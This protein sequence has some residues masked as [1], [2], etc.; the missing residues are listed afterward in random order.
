MHFDALTLA[1][2]ADE[3]RR[4]LNDGRVQQVL[5]PNALSVGLEI[6]AHHQRHYLML[7]TG[8]PTGRVFLASDKLRRGVEQPSP[9][10]LLLRK[11]LR[12]SSVVAIQQPSPTERVLFLQFEHAEHGVAT[13]I[14]EILGQRSNLILRNQA[15][16]ILECLHRVWPGERVVRPLAPGQ[17]YAL[18]PPQNKL[19]PFDDGA[20]EYYTQLERLIQ[21]E[22]K[23]WKV[24]STGVAGV[25]PTLGR[26]IA[27]RT[28]GDSEAS[29]QETPLLGLIQALQGLWA[30]VQTGE[31]Q[32]GV[33]L[34][35]DHPVGYSAYV[36]HLDGQFTPTPSMSQ[37]L[38]AYYGRQQAGTVAPAQDPYAGLRKT[39][40]ASLRRAQQRIQRQLDALAGDE[41]PPGAAEELRTEAEWLLALHTQIQPG[42]QTLAVDL[43]DK[44]L[45]IALDPQQTPVQQAEQMFKRSRR[46]ERAAQFIP[47]R[48]ARLQEDQAFLV[49]LSADLAL[50]E[51]QPEIAAVGDELQ[52]AGLLPEQGKKA[53][54]QRLSQQSAQP[55]RY[56]SPQGFEIVV[57]RNARQNERVT[58]DIAGSNDLWLHVRGAPGSHVVIRSGGQPVHDTTLH[59]AAQLAAY[60]SNLRGERAAVV[61]YTPRRSVSRA[62]GG[63]TGQVLVR[64]EQTLTVRAELPP[65][66]HE[67]RMG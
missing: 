24:L 21:S 25:S 20:P 38:E 11:Y 66:L 53:P 61:A 9:L 29:A 22:G 52:R 15:G 19:S 46:M 23:L 67:A 14:L 3:L 45:Q 12:N 35:N 57:G 54:R 6:Y 65:D 4:T 62:P 51:N 33:W 42:Q 10:L 18:P 48:R 28:A 60:Y 37:A 2:M 44:T 43:G 7:A 27:R 31:W 47:Q 49:Q 39:V 8:E 64:N 16:R 5:A 34:E 55:R 13:L 40:T 36:A 63:H 1:C 56:L 59:M 50:A 17:I 26:E 58:F 30:P 41:P 32:P